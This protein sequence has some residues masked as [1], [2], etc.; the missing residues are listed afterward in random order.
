LAAFAL[1]AL[2]V[3]AFII[4][5]TFS[6]VV[7]QRLR[8]MALLRAI[9]ASRRQVLGSVIGESFAV[10]LIASAIGVVAGIF[11]AIGLKALLNAIGFGLPGS[12][13]VVRPSAII[14]GLL[15]GTIVTLISSV[16]PA[17]QA[18][19]IP[20]IAAMRSVALERPLNRVLRSA[21][22]VAIT[23]L[24]VLLLLLGLFGGHGIG[25]VA[26]GALLILLGVFVLSPLFAHGMAL[27]IGAPLR[28]IKGVTG[29]LARENAARN[30]RR[31]AT[32]GAAVMIAVSLVGFITIF[33]A[34]ANASISSAIDNQLK[35][36]YIITSGGGNGALTGLSPTLGKQIAALPVIQTVAPVRLGQVGINDGR[37]FVNAT[38]AKAGAQLLDLNGVAGSFAAIENNGIAVSKRKADAN[39]WKI[40]SVIPTTFVETGQLPLTVRYIYKANTFGDYFISL[41]TYEK[42]F[43]EQLDFL[44]LAKLKPGVSADQGRKAIE[45]LLKPYPTA[46]LKDN[47]QYKADQKKQVNQVLGLFY[48]L[49]FLAVIIAAIGITNTMTLSIHERTHEIGLLRAVGESRR[50]VRSMVRW[51]AVIIAL[52]GTLLG[53][54]IALFFGWAVI[55]ALQDQ[56]FSK[57]SPALVQLAIIV[58]IGGFAAVVA[59][60]LPAR[61]AARL[62]IL[63]AITHE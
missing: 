33:A 51:E 4:Y 31:T 27:A 28:R 26:L 3:G 25:A 56:G 2:I 36:D 41:K 49:L 38:D 43:T 14:V 58:V 16:V 62:D 10:G 40:G 46:K 61:R 5:N 35:T 47:A 60:I 32:T 20:P 17:R 9:G 8:E 13:V 45:P 37:A 18:S 42:N 50:Q 23:S 44:I 59:A 6:I 34:S 21:I 48:V 30:P 24:G 19:R 57:F 54:V 63:N 15:A 12:G 1:I 22:G 52:L 53:V 11:V 29:E 39:H 7:A 55:K